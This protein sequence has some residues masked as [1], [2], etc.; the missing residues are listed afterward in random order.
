MNAVLL[1]L[2]VALLLIVLLQVGKVLEL[3]G[4]VRGKEEAEESTNS[5]NAFLLTLT[6]FACLVYCIVSVFFYKDKF[7]PVAASEYGVAIDKV[8][9]ITLYI[10]GIVFV[11]TQI[12]LFVFVY[13]YQYKKDRKAYYFPD[14][15]KLEL[16]PAGS[17]GNFS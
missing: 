17:S 15:N 14:N 7:L 1:I 8:Q 13:R 16:G 9:Q 2:A 5:V 3:I 6:G 4:I 12:L 11:I 10:T